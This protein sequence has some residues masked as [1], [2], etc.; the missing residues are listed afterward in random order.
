[1]DAQ[2]LLRRVER[3]RNIDPLLAPRRHGMSKVGIGKVR[4]RQPAGLSL[5]I[6]EQRG[7]NGFRIA[8]VAETCA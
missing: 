8:Q 5:S 4:G 1:M 3:Q 6:A 7:W 2:V